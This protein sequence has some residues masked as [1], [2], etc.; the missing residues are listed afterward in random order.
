MQLT[1]SNPVPG[2][3]RRDATVTFTVSAPLGSSITIEWPP[4][5]FYGFPIRYEITGPGVGPSS[6]EAQPQVSDNPNALL[7]P[8][9]IN[10]RYFNGVCNFFLKA[11]IIFLVTLPS[12]L[13]C[14]S[15]YRPDSLDQ[16]AR[17]P[18]DF[19]ILLWAP[20]FL[21]SDLFL[22]LSLPKTMRG[23][24]IILVRIMLFICPLT[25]TLCSDWWCCDGYFP[26]YR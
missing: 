18:S 16:R 2:A 5:Y 11:T 8:W 21:H 20:P 26:V 15:L 24:A 3:T 9:V 12:L 7:P 22:L 1:L 4:G 17:T 25:Y 19:Q 14:R 10:S 23:L 6:G 13:R